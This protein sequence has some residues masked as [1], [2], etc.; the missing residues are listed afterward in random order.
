M[1]LTDIREFAFSAMGTEC[2]LLLD[3]E[4]SLAESA[5]DAAM[6]EVF[7]I[8]EKYSRYRADGLMAEINAAAQ[9]G[10]E[11]EVDEETAALLDYAFACYRKSAGLFDITSGLLRQAWNF[12]SA[13]LPTQRAIDELL[14]RVGLENIHWERPQL[15]FDTPA[16]ELDFGGIGKEYAADRVADICVEMG[17][18]AGIVDLGGDIRV[19]GPRPNGEPWIVHIRHPRMTDTPLLTLGLFKGAVASSGDYERFMEVD[20]KRYCHIL[21]PRTGWP[22][23]GMSSATVVSDRCMV[24]GAL[25]TIAMLKGRDAPEWLAMLNVPHVWMDAEGKQGEMGLEELRLPRQ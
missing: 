4:A 15:R 5:A 25:S 16:M 21:N 7:R 22:V 8:E 11:I 1:A 24:A 23:Q 14:P 17:A 18:S 13:K 19:I 6:G 10:S 2:R 20:G 12:D 3:C 9:V